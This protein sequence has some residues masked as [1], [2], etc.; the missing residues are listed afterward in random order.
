MTPGNQSVFCR[1]ERGQVTGFLTSS[2]SRF[3]SL[4]PTF[5]CTPSFYSRIFIRRHMPIRIYAKCRIHQPEY[6]FI[7]DLEQSVVLL[8]R[9][10]IYIA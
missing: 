4:P 10:Q 2:P 1:T 8:L 5:G 6:K 7:L 3:I 9:E